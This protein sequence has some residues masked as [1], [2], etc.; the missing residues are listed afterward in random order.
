MT[1]VQ[2]NYPYF[3]WFTDGILPNN[4]YFSNSLNK[5]DFSWMESIKL[6]LGPT[7]SLDSLII[8]S[9]VLGNNNSSKLTTEFAKSSIF[10]WDLKFLTSYKT[11]GT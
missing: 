8:L 1:Y 9:I 3:D 7:M 6:G 2:P 5:T 4:K 10:E 11:L